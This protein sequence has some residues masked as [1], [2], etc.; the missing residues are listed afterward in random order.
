[1]LFRSKFVDKSYSFEEAGVIAYQGNT[2]VIYHD[3]KGFSLDTENKH[4]FKD[5]LEFDGFHMKA[6]YGD[7]THTRDLCANRLLEQ[8]YL[9]RHSYIK[10]PYQKYNDFSATYLNKVQGGAK[11]HVDGFPIRLYINDTYWGLYSLNIKK[12]RD[13]FLLSKSNVNHIQIEAANDKI[14]RAHV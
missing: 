13:N 5:W 6:Y 2:S 14:G 3:K 10:R 4:K 11:C 9:N 1:M 12:D 7:W 8:F